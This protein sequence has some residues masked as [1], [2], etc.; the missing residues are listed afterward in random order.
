M[1]C[2]V[3]GTS[4]W[5]AGVL[6]EEK[7][8]ILSSFKCWDTTSHT[9]QQQQQKASS[10]C[11]MSVFEIWW[12]RPSVPRLGA[13]GK[14]EESPPVKRIFTGPAA[15]AAACPSGL[16]RDRAV[17]SLWVLPKQEGFWS[18]VRKLIPYQ[19]S[20]TSL[21]QVHQTSC[22]PDVFTILWYIW[23]TCSITLC[24]NERSSGLCES[25]WKV[26]G[27]NPCSSLSMDSDWLHLAGLWLRTSVHCRHFWGQCTTS[28]GTGWAVESS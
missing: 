20:P 13:R 28:V 4:G 16:D 27:S 8:N 12:G 18:H 22:R 15:P 1:S 2:G 3:G 14:V 21:C 11:V 25:K 19:S 17:L 6:C 7:H 5:A 24:F 23:C 10:T 26:A 9:T